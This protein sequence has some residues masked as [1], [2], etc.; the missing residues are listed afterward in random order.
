MMPGTGKSSTIKAVAN[1]L[2]RHI[3]NF[4]SIQTSIQLYDLF[5]SEYIHYISNGINEKVKIPIENRLYVLEE[6]D[7]LGKIVLER[8]ECT[9]QEL[10]PGQMCLGDILNILDGNNEY[11]GRVTSNF[12]GSFHI[13]E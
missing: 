8:S 3:I 6:I 4:A 5:N 2:N 1:E 12:P 7:T 9:T 13:T 10:V 11:P